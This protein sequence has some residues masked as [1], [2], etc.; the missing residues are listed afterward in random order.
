MLKTFLSLFLLLAVA[1][2]SVAQLSEPLVTGARGLAMGGTGLNVQDV[3]AAW[4]NPAGLSSIDHLGF[5]FYGEQ[6]FTLTE[7]KQVSAVAAMP[8]GKNGG[9][10]LVLGY[11]GF[12]AYNEQRIG[13]AYGRKLSEKISLGTQLYSWS[14]R[15]PEYGSKTALSF[16]LGIQVK[17]SSQVSM[18]GKVINPARIS[19]IDEEYLPTIMSVGLLYKPGKGIS[20]AAEAEKDVLHPLRVKIGIEYNLLEAIDL[21]LGVVTSETQLS[22]GFGY[23]LKSHWQLNFATTYHQYLGFTPGIGLTYR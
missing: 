4:G 17:I 3:H 11:Y 20:I 16:E 21:R 19:V 8:M 5:S 2:S 22:F 9:I 18:G 6:R 7:L 12:D 13:I 10:G 23:R 15:I 1:T 14:T